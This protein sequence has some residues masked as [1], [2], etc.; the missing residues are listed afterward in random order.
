MLFAF[1]LSL[2][3]RAQKPPALTQPGVRGWCKGADGEDGGGPH[4]CRQLRGK[5]WGQRRGARASGAEGITA[6]RAILGRMPGAGG[7]EGGI[8]SVQ[9]PQAR[10]GF[11]IFSARMASRL[12][13]G[14]AVPSQE[15]AR[16][17]PRTPVPARCWAPVSLG[18]CREL[19]RSAGRSLYSP[20]MALLRLPCLP[21]ALHCQRNAPDARIAAVIS[22]L[23][24]LKL[25]LSPD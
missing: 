19:G 25:L 2:L 9:N 21:A 14:T 22:A 16:L 17:P 4:Y 23:S 11:G 1:L 24:L 18:S 13:A 15:P 12:T 7:G 8:L 5:T 10:R 6:C 20:Q 3:C